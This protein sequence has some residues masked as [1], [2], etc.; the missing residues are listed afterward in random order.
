MTVQIVIKPVGIFNR[1]NQYGEV[2]AG[3]MY[4][5]DNVYL[6]KSGTLQ[7]MPKLASP[8]TSA[9]TILGAT[10]NPAILASSDVPGQS[11]Q[12]V[13]MVGDQGSMQ[14]VN[15]SNTATATGTWTTNVHGSFLATNVVPIANRPF[16]VKAR[17][18]FHVLSDAG[19]VVHDNLLP[20]STSQARPRFPG[21]PQPVIPGGGSSVVAAGGV[22]TVNGQHAAYRALVRRK[23]ADSYE[24]LSVPSTP[25]ERS[26]SGA[27]PG[28]IFVGVAIPDWAQAGL[29]TVE[30]YRTYIRDAAIDPGPTFYL[31]T[32]I[33]V[34]AGNVNTSFNIKDNTA[35]VALTTELYT[36][37][38][39]ETDEGA[40]R[41]P[42]IARNIANYKGYTFYANLTQPPLLKLGVSQ[43]NNVSMVDAAIRDN[44]VGNRIGTGTATN[45][46]PT[47]TAI[48]AA[49]IAGLIVGQHLSITTPSR[50]LDNSTIISKTATSITL[51]KNAT[52]AG[53]ATF[54]IFDVLW[55]RAAVGTS[56]N[57]FLLTGPGSLENSLIQAG[58]TVTSSDL[59]VGSVTRSTITAT[60]PYPRN[61]T[62]DFSQIEVFATNG[63]QYTP[64]LPEPPQATGPIISDTGYI[65]SET[66]EPN[67]GVFSKFNEPEA[68]PVTNRF[69]CGL[70][71]IVGL[72]STRDALWFSCTDGIW[73]LSG[74]G[75]DFRLDPVDSTLNLTGPQSWCVLRDNVYQYTNQGFIRISSD[76]GIELLSQ[77]SVNEMQGSPYAEEQPFR[78][79]YDEVENEVHFSFTPQLFSTALLAQWYVFN[80]NTGAFTRSRQT[81]NFSRPAAVYAKYVWNGGNGGI[82]W[83]G[84]LI[85]SS[86]L[87][88]MY[89]LPRDYFGTSIAVADWG[90]MPI[91][92]G[93]PRTVKQWTNVTHLMQVQN[94]GQAAG[95]FLVPTW[96]EISPS[97]QIDEAASNGTLPDER[98]VF[99]VPRT[100]SIAPMLKTGMNVTSVNASDDIWEYQGFAV[101]YIEL[102]TQQKGRR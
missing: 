90:F 49:D 2:P 94:T 89:Q 85:A 97:T 21:V 34:T 44:S 77:A 19:P 84:K 35:N 63:A 46:S 47:L 40:N 37:P 22:W 6:R 52:S 69:R 17:D 45:G 70:G 99:W 3:A 83:A 76:R 86:T 88:I 10:E 12:Q 61:D 48:S 5:A 39:Q 31:L 82:L 42:P 38:G 29:D 74:D 51:S 81:S 68:V 101:E 28:Y 59:P 57:S 41:T 100:A 58:Y 27:P 96:N 79:T 53:A 75:G 73:R 24:L 55:Y 93:D 50:G 7:P 67:G 25:I 78:M 87:W 13:M 36:N 66:E 92:G 33:P 16:Y 4:L 62:F 56:F 8:Y 1:P 9:T 54:N 80:A 98:V 102:T 23:F 18:R 71:T 15:S 43:A 95:P 30:I 20:A 32:A 91:Y 11:V 64:N 60:P 65:V 72:A 26:F 14:W